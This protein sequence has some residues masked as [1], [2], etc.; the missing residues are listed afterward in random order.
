MR[1]SIRCSVANPDDPLGFCALATKTVTNS[2]NSAERIA[3][4][5]ANTQGCRHYVGR[6]RTGASPRRIHWRPASGC[7]MRHSGSRHT[8]DAAAPDT[9]PQ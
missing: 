9:Q 2:T 7:R 8:P 3:D 6:L 5:D 1:F 4:V